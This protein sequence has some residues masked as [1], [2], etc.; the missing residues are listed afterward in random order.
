MREVFVMAIRQLVVFN[1]DDEEFGIDINFVNSIEKP[2]EIFK[3]PNVPAFIEG[4]INL[5]GKVH[6]VINL[7]KR[8]NLPTREF[9]EST[10]IIIVNANSS[11]VGFIVDEVKKIIRVDDDTIEG[12]PPVI[13]SLKEKFISGVAK[14]DGRVIIILDP[15]G[16]ITIE[17]ND[18]IQEPVEEHVEAPAEES[19]E[20]S[21]DKP[22]EEPEEETTGEPT[23]EPVV[24]IAKESAEEP[25]NEPT[26]EPAVEVTEEP[27]EEPADEP[28]KEPGV[29][30]AE[31]PAEEPADDEPTEE[32]AVEMAVEPAEE[33][34]DEPTEEPADE[35]AEKPAEESLKNRHKNR[36]KNRRKNK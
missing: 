23:G 36:R 22:A 11:I 16:I 3:I 10:K 24:E 20:A 21:V 9:D 34:A 28:T 32:P 30:M 4:L 8:L 25:A 6:T 12:A 35:L 14:I 33:P 27:A 19:A 13:S 5:R 15:S 1:I 17:E 26:E 29:E 31:E 7:R 18:L 2:L